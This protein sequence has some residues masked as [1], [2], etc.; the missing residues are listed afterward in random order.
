MPLLV[1]L[2]PGSRSTRNAS[3][4]V[5]DVKDVCWHEGNGKIEVEG[6]VDKAPP[7]HFCVRTGRHDVQADRRKIRE[8]VQATW[9][10]CR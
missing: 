2:Y 3:K 4:M 7:S 6:G 10:L 8:P 5:E 1:C 9:S